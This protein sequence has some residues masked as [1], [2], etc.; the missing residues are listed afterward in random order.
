MPPDQGAASPAREHLREV[1]RFIVVGVGAVS[2]DAAGYALLVRFLGPDPAKASSFIAGALFGFWLNR[3]WTFRSQGMPLVQ[4]PVFSAVYATSFC[5]NVGVN[6]LVLRLWP[7]A[8]T[9][10]FLA[11][12][13]TSTVMNFLGMKF[14][15]FRR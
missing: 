9:P 4:L 14:L 3:S 12:T 2:V 10:G 6:H 13:A 1:L 15:V 11:A 7:S 8:L 5:A